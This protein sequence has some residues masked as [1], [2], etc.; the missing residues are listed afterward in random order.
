MDAERRP[1][2]TPGELADHLRMS[3]ATLA[4]WRYKGIGPRFVKVGKRVLYR[5]AD[6]DAWLEEQT[7]QGTADAPAVA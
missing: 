2:F 6:V 3:N 5:P 1:F 4:G 7:R